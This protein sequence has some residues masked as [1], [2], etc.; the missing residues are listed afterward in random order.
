LEEGEKRSVEEVVEEGHLGVEA[1]LVSLAALVLHGT[2]G[3]PHVSCHGEVVS[4]VVI[5]HGLGVGVV[6]PVVLLALAHDVFDP[7]D[8]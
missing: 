5:A 2:S 1:I 3:V 8:L 4:G 7:V 6:V